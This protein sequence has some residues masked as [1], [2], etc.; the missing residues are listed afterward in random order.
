MLLLSCGGQRPQVLV[1]LLVDTLRAD[2]LGCYGSTTVKTP[3]IDRLAAE[4]ILYEQAVTAVPV[5]LP[6]IATLLTGAYPVQHGIRDNGPYQLDKRWTTMA[7]RLRDAGW[8]TG[9]F[10]SASVLS[11]DHK[12]DQGFDTYDD[13]MSMPY[14]PHHPLLLPMAERLQGI[15]RRANVTV[16]RAL[17]WFEETMRGNTF[18]FV[19]LF[20]PHLPYDPPPP[21]DAE[22]RGRPYEGEIAYVDGEIGRLLEGLR[23]TARGAEIRLVFL[24]DHGE[25]LGDH[26]EFYHGDLLFEET[27]H[28]PLIL[29][30]PGIPR[31]KRVPDLVRMV[32]I[33]PTLCRLHGLEVPEGVGAPLPGLFGGGQGSR[34]RVAYLETFRP[35][36][37]NNWCE[38]RGLRTDAWKVISG[39]E[40]ELYDL[41][42]DPKETLNLALEL[43]SVCDSLLQLMDATALNAARK[44]VHHAASLE[45]SA[46]QRERLRSLGYITAGSSRPAAS[47]TLAVWYF[48]PEER[49]LA[50]GLPNPRERVKAGHTR[51]VANSFCQAGQ[52]FL[53]DGKYEEAARS[54]SEA[55]RHNEG[56]CDAY[57][58]LAESAVRSHHPEHAAETLKRAGKRFRTD[59]RTTIDIAD[60]LVRIGRPV[61]ALR[62]ID[63][64]IDAVG[65]AN[66]L[67][68]AKRA[69]LA[70]LAGSSPPRGSGVPGKGASRTL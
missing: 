8:D 67:L 1:I 11:S 15:E 51:I 46:Q 25:G 50:L 59:A 33:L 18:L 26:G 57:F 35:R 64:A 4:G 32:D 17:A 9:A 49:G 69:A 14:E 7:E 36:L 62:V 56:L 66:P 5:T 61:A 27:V 68:L 55:I 42:S 45:M 43:E 24:A 3:Q 23:R 41:R 44:G 40:P 65:R 52:A 10:V 38:L 53:A 58:G 31:G 6:S 29:H 37:A 12:L 22:Y 16:D 34:G 54:F 21:F 70:R 39:P 30:G 13:D 47:D 48:P 19:H 60:A 2:R 20:D 28:V 63:D